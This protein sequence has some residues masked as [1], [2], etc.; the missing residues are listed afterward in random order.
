MTR[1]ST[2]IRSVAALTALSATAFPQPPQA[3]KPNI[4]F[5]LMDNL[6]YGEVGVTE[7]ACCAVLRRPESTSSPPKA[8]G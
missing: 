6:G 7:A 5:V 4:V 1:R 8:R 3:R 2:I